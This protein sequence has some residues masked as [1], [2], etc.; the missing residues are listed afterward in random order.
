MHT[1]GAFPPNLT[2]L[3]P[4]WPEVRGRT[5]DEA[6]TFLFSKVDSK[7]KN[8]SVF[9][10]NIDSRLVTIAGPMTPLFFGGRDQFEFRGSFILSQVFQ[11]GKSFCPGHSG[12]KRAQ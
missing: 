8:F 7:R 3:S 6:F 4:A 10:I 5:I 2:F 11:S 1:K 9:G 12:Q